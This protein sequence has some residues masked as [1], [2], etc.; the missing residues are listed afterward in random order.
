M[1]HEVIF[2]IPLDDFPRLIRSV[3]SHSYY[4]FKIISAGEPGLA[5]KRLYLHQRKE[6]ERWARK[7][8]T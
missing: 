7:T 8:L 1:F 4:F 5:A 2:P 3:P 6:K